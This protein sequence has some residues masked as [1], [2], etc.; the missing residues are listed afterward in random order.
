[1]WAEVAL[2]AYGAG[3]VA[4]LALAAAA[5]R[6]GSQ[7]LVRARLLLA[8]GVLAGALALPLTEQVR[9][10]TTTTAA[11]HPYAASEVVVTEGAA[12]ELLRGRAPYAARFASPELAGRSPSIP[13][14]FPYLPGMAAFGL[15]GALAPGTPWA[16]A[17][18][19][20]G[21]ATAIAAGLAIALWGAPPGR[22]LRA[23]QVL[24][25]LPTGATALVAG[26]DGL[27]V[28][29]LSLLALVLFERGRHAASASAIAAASLLKLTAWPLLVAL[30]LSGR[31]SGRKRPA[32]PL[33]LAVGVVGLGVLGAVAA[34]PA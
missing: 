19:F 14:H 27:P 17:R 22:R 11:L 23:L 10:R 31:A 32:P 18:I 33:V 7:R 12:G 34:G 9:L 5:A 21:L 4:A 29:A 25:V 6:L 26:S 28:L 2:P 30:A 16:D 15:P 3:A 1:G 20:F 13:Q 8:L 24:L